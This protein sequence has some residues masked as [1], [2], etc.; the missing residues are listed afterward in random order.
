MDE[1]TMTVKDL[2]EFLGKS[3]QIILRTAKKVD[4]LFEQGIEKKFNK[5]EVEKISKC[6]YKDLPKVLKIAIE[7]SFDKPLF[8]NETVDKLLFQNETVDKPLFQNETVA[9]MTN[10]KVSI[11]SSS[12]LTIQ[13]SQL[14]NVEEL[15]KQLFI[16]NELLKSQINSQKLLL[17]QKS[18]EELEFILPSEFFDLHKEDFG[19]DYKEDKEGMHDC[20]MSCV[21][22][23]NR[24]HKEIKY[25]KVPDKWGFSKR[26]HISILE[27]IFD[28][29]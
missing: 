7:E 19:A 14:N 26:F 11:V 27:R 16:Q 23:S 8:Q 20:L 24:L 6:L 4:I 15:I 21:S 18:D 13:N 12:D 10:E 5:S 25:S 29:R 3:K 2:V 28:F 17:T 9:P 1:I 22:E